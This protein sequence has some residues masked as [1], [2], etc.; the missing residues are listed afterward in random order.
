MSLDETLFESIQ[1][2]MD[3][4][5]I[6]EVMQE[7]KSGKEATVFAC[8]GRSGLLAVKVYRP[9]EHRHFH[10]NTMYNAGKVILSGRVRRA[11]QNRSEFGKQA[12][13][14]MW[15]HTEWEYL[16]E[17][18]DAELDVPRP[19]DRGEQ[20]IVMEYLG[21]ETSPAPQLRSV[22]LTEVQA[23][24]TWN[25]LT[26]NIKQMLRLN[27]IHGDLSPYNLLWWQD[28]AW[29]ID[30]PQ[31]V[32]PRMNPNAYAILSRDLENCWRHLSKFASL[33]DP[34]KLA[35]HLWHLFKHSRL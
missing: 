29:I 2:F 16:H 6:T 3:K 4:G 1:P 21:D 34:W 12:A 30:L 24:Q 31:M 19:I 13:L 23:T 22:K 7:L 25:R 5:L 33:P 8:R 32:D 10:N 27:R 14:G 15:V 28:R 9:L 20:T 11:V 35:G 18:Y 17:L 26:W